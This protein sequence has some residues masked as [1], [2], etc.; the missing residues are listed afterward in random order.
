MQKIWF[1][2]FE[3]RQ[4]SCRIASGGN[5][6]WT[7]GH[8]IKRGKYMYAYGTHHP[9]STEESPAA[10]SPLY[11]NLHGF[12]QHILLISTSQS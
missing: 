1:F 11:G 12:S 2:D 3:A 7:F 5:A 8:A 4:W 10:V 9:N 6:D